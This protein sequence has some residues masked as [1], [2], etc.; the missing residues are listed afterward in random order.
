MGQNW[1]IGLVDDD[2]LHDWLERG[3][4][5]NQNRNGR[6]KAQNSQKKKESGK[7]LPGENHFPVAPGRGGRTGSPKT[8]QKKP[9]K[10]PF[11]L[12]PGPLPSVSW[13]KP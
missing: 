2:F 3:G 1:H 13:V 5:G 8:F 7:G 11:R 4:G 6:K 9:A 12:K 10:T